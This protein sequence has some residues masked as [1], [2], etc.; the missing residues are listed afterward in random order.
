MPEGTN[1]GFIHQV[2]EDI[3]RTAAVLQVEVMGAILG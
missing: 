1:E 3:Q 2:M